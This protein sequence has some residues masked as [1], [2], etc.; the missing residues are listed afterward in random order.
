MAEPHEPA[1]D[2]EASCAAY[3]EARTI[4]RETGNGPCEGYT[5]FGWGEVEIEAGRRGK[6]HRFFTEAAELFDAAGMADWRSSALEKAAE[7]EG[8]TG[9]L[10]ETG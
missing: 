1:Q 9:R 8:R 4:Y 5:L 6:A 2:I 3:A 10:A 7:A